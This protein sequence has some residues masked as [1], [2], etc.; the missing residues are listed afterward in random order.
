MIDSR[1]NLKN[2]PGSVPWSLNNS[3]PSRALRDTSGHKS[4]T[5]KADRRINDKPASNVAKGSV[6]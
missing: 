2:Q 6:P 1:K 3:S 4:N 5:S